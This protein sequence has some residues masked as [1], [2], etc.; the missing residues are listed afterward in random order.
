[1][2]ILIQHQ[3]YITK[4]ERKG[5]KEKKNMMIEA[6][7]ADSNQAVILPQR[8]VLSCTGLC[9]PETIQLHRMSNDCGLD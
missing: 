3:Q 7:P 2:E 5:G 1:M 6:P 8:A 9:L 4:G